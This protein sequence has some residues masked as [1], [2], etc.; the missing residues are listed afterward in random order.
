NRGHDSIVIMAVDQETGGLRLVG[1]VPCGGATPRNLALT[2]SGG[3][4]FS[5]NQNADRISIF[6][7][8]ASTGMLTDTGRAIEIGTPMCVKIVG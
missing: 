3:H 8:D 1:Y 6:A 5:A 7:R 2:P 4:L